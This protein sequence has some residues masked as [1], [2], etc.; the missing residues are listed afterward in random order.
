MHDS[1]R[2]YFTV[3]HSVCVSNNTHT[4]GLV[5]YCTSPQYLLQS[6][7]ETCCIA[8]QQCQC[9]CCLWL[10]AVKKKRKLELR[11]AESTG[12]RLMRCIWAVACNHPR[13]EFKREQWVAFMKEHPEVLSWNAYKLDQ[14]EGAYTGISRGAHLIARHKDKG[15]KGVNYVTEKG[16]AWVKQ[17]LSSELP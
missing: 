16:V 14:H 6:V 7:S 5:T 12:F 9:Q 2:L 15:K 17:H 11:H 8:C 1:S 13:F 3:Q 4:Y 10:P